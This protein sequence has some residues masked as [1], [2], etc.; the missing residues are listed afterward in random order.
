MHAP[1]TRAEGTHSA[2]TAVESCGEG[3]VHDDV[4]EDDEQVLL[5]LVPAQVFHNIHMV[6]LLQQVYLRLCGEKR[7]E[8]QKERE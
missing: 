2:H 8:R 3:H 1:L 5:R 7:R 4:L 6:Q